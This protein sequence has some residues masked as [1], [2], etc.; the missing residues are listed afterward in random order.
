MFISTLPCG[1]RKGFM[2]A[3]RAFWGTTKK[4]ENK[5]LFFSLC[6]ESGPEGSIFYF[7]TILFLF[8]W[9]IVFKKGSTSN[10]IKSMLESLC[11]VSFN[12]ILVVSPVESNFLIK[13][14]INRLYQNKL[15]KLLKGTLMHIW[16]SPFIFV[17]IQK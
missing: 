5:N 2:K 13:Y 1:V 14:P 9:H 4:C 10:F 17:F 12:S 16:K 8:S 6:P 11:F 3:L 7:K 15:P